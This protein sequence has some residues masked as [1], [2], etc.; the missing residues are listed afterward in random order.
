MKTEMSVKCKHLG[1]K[2]WTRISYD[3]RRESREP[4]AIEFRSTWKCSRHSRLGD[5]L[6]REGAN[7]EKQKIVTVVQKGEGKCF[8]GIFGIISGP[9]FKAFADDFPEGTK[10]FVTAKVILPEDE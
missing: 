3:T 4:K 10:I 1:C 5:V 2:E 6:S 8:D 7:S 9:G